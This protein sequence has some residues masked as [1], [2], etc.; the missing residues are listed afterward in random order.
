MKDLPNWDIFLCARY[1]NKTYHAP[2]TKRQVIHKGRTGTGGDMEQKRRIR[3]FIRYTTGNVLGMLG[4]SCYILA[5]TYFISKGM[6]ADGLTAL[7]LA[8][9][10]YSLIYGSGLMLGIGGAAKYSVFC[11][12]GNHRAA[13]EV[14]INTIYLA[15]LFS[16]LFILAGV[17]FDEKLTW[18]LGADEAVFAMTH[19]YIQTLLLFAPCFLLN[20]IAICFVRNDGNPALAMAAMLAGSI[21]NIILDYIFI[22]PFHLNMFGAVLAT[23]FA[24]IISMGVLSWHWIKKQSHIRFRLGK[25]MPSRQKPILSLGI[26]SL[27]AETSS[28]VVILVFNYIIMGIRGNIGVAA[29]GVIANLSL[30]VTAV[31]TG[32]AQGMQP[33]LSRAYGKQEG[34]NALEQILGYGI[35]TLLPISIGVYLL[36][37]LFAG[38]VAGVFNG[39]NNQELQQIAE[40]GMRLYFIGIPFAGVN[41]VLSMYFTAIEKA[42]FAQLL[43]ILRGFLLM[44]PMAFLL[45]WLAEMQGIWLTYTI[46]EGLVFLLGLFLLYREHTKGNRI[47]SRQ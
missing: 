17:F 23:G 22:F 41:I 33:L 7:N 29:Y 3:E 8:I 37:F 2:H 30:V 4:L 44:L 21:S 12:Q 5:D 27:I 19:V 11:G 42:A 34:Q 31:F 24:P 16:L 36:F 13:D 45:A 39:E 38:P 28:G 6:G 10:V 43:S 9:P 40:T 26:S 32:I 18:L 35:K 25:P 14:V 47:F 46:T 15:V 20:E 1:D